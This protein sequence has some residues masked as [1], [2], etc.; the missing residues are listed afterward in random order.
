M[1]AKTKKVALASLFGTI[2]FL[3]KVAVPSPIDKLFI[4]I[5]AVLLSLGALLLGMM[6]AT[7]VAVI[8]GLLTALWRFS[9]APFTFL[10]AFIYGLLTDFSLLIF[11]VRAPEGLVDVKRLTAAM[12]ISSALMG[13]ISYYATVYLF[14]L[15]E[16][17]PPLEIIIL[18]AGTVN[19]MLAGYLSSIIWN[20]Y[21]K[22]IQL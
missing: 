1:I 17:N 6:G 15:L 20:R 16:R 9:S 5:Q 2:I 12:T 22:N 7:Y 10:F 13:L 11:K 8:G 14:N 4:V 19:G 21:L 18:A 3:S